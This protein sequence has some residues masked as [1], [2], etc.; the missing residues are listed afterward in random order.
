M[1]GDVGPGGA[2][3]QDAKQVSS[4]ALATNDIDGAWGIWHKASGAASRRMVKHL[5]Y[6]DWSA[7]SQ[8]SELNRLWLKVRRLHAK[9][10]RQADEEADGLLDQASIILE[11]AEMNRI[12]KWQERV[13]TRSGASKWIKA[14][15]AARKLPEDEDF[16]KLHCL[17]MKLLGKLLKPFHRDGTRASIVSIGRRTVCPLCLLIL[18]R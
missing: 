8:L 5:P 7:G 17:W 14:K 11:D 4:S 15:M 13:T 18:L 10:S 9:R 3:T 6:G 12:A 16:D 2:W 1:R